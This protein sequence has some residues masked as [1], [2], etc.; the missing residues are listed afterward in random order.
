MRTFQQKLRALAQ[1]EHQ[2]FLLLLALFAA[3]RLLTLFLFRPGGFIVD[4]SDYDFYREWGT[5]IPMGYRTFESLWTVYPPLF[6][7]FML[8]IFEWSSRVPQ[9][10]EP[11]L[12]FH[13]LFGS[14]ILL[15]E[16]GNFICIYWLGRRL[17]HEDA[18]TVT[19]AGKPTATA[20]SL[21]PG[22]WPAILYGFLFTPV[23]TMAGW[24][25]PMPLFFLLLGLC[26]LIAGKKWWLLSAVAAALGFLV[27]L[28]P[29][30]LVPIAIRWL[31][32]RLSLRAAREAWFNPRHP[33]NLL[34]AT[35]YT[36][37]FF[38]VVIGLGYPLVGYNLDL[39]FVSFQIQPL[40][41]SWQS[42]WALLDGY[43]SW[44][45][46]PLSMKNIEGL[47]GEP[48]PTRLPWT[49]ISIAFL[50]VYLF[51]YT[52]A[53]N[54][55]RVRTPIAFAGFSVTLL[56]LYSKGWSPQFLVWNLV[57]IVLLLPNPRWV[58]AA[59]LLSVAN[60]LESS[61]YLLV[62][63]SRI[64]LYGT[65]ILRTGLLLLLCAEL[66]WQIWPKPGT[67]PQ[68]A[69]A[70]QPGAQPAL[71]GAWLARATWVFMLVAIIGGLASTPRVLARYAERQYQYYPCR[72][73]VETLAQAAPWPGN[74]LITQQPE[75]WH[76]MNPFVYRDYEFVIVDGYN[77]AADPG[78][79]HVET[80]LA[81]L[82][83]QIAQ[84]QPSPGTGKAAPELW[85]VERAGYTYPGSSPPAIWET[86]VAH[87]DVYTVAEYKTPDD[88]RG[89]CTLRRVV[90]LRAGP[91]V[92]AM[93]V[94]TTQVAAASESAETEAEISLRDFAWRVEPATGD[95][96]L[97]LYWQ[98]SA[99]AAQSYT[100][101]V[102][103]LDATG[104]PVGQQDNLPV[105]GLAPTTHWTPGALIRDPYHLADLSG[106][107]AT[108]HVGL[109]N[110]AGRLQLQLADGTQKDHVEISLTP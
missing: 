57:F 54:W 11:R 79:Q 97:T 13:L 21:P 102:H 3:F 58:V 15:F 81:R 100:V 28:T 90:D 75:L 6:P 2:P 36:L 52:R 77:T 5:L 67:L 24:F 18:E 108:I 64:L 99:P 27:K 33:D 56:F 92:A 71:F 62:V 53:Y 94:A 4:H 12:I 106:E 47:D 50:A 20:A 109:Y 83:E 16:C 72:A 69:V 88:A 76:E 10:H 87:P 80:G 91:Q 49:A 23:Y 9:Y 45:L 37:I 84:I 42:I 40:R 19:T 78:E 46:V 44:G 14:V 66:L 60:L 89:D 107:P 96:R 68:S 55:Q 74:V 43:H 63:P 73:T 103:A 35:L 93:S 65:V 95:L 1:G 22:L 59:I 51:F 34:R 61:I 85:W 104:A 82:Q 101:F 38:A 48:W 98:S 26:L 25:E 105:N 110:A 39:A 31:G 8:T 86:F 7:A 29:I 30:M 32:A 17:A 41:P 70:E